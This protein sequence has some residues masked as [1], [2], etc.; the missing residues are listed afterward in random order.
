MSML[1]R[2]ISET[3][4]YILKDRRDEGAYDFKNIDKNKKP[5]KKEKNPKKKQKND[6]DSDNDSEKSGVDLSFLGSGKDKSTKIDRDCNHI[7]FYCEV[8]RDNVYELSQLIREAEEENM[9]TSFKLKIDKIPI[10]LHISSY[11]GTIFDAFTLIDVI[12][13]CKSPV[14]SII[15]GASASAATI[16]SVVAEKR[17]I[18]PSAYMLIHQ[19]SS[20]FWG[21]MAEIED[22]FAN[23]K[24]L[25][26]KIKTI[27]K[28]YTKIPKKELNE[29][30]KHDLW[31][32]ADKCIK[33]GLVDEI[34]TN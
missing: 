8:D 19:L 25:M 22:D 5:E 28:T 17:F 1:K 20:G 24:E 23:L 11:G 14:Y 21:K 34:W 13:S 9:L 15:E 3:Y 31:L 27:Y 7:Y 12:K 16:I 18:T 32:N 4:S 10:Y 26:E 29:L 33:Y 30:L 2:K 6:N